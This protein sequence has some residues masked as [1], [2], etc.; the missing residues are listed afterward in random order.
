MS[1][2][3]GESVYWMSSPFQREYGD[4]NNEN[5]D[6]SCQSEF[7]KGIYCGSKFLEENHATFHHHRNDFIYS[8]K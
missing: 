1:N 3:S 7:T 5:F 6:A 8:H 4:W 2:I